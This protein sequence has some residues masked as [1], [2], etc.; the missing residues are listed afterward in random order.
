MTP[1]AS[2]AMLEKLALLK[3]AL[4]RAPALSSASSAFWRTELS[5]PAEMPVRVFVPPFSP[6]MALPPVTCT[7]RIPPIARTTSRLRREQLFNGALELIWRVRLG[8]EVRAFNKQSFHLVG[9]G[10]ACRVEHTQ[11]WRRLDGL[12]CKLT[13]AEDRCFEMDIGKECV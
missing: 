10:I 7:C 12:V 6:V 4:C 9:N 2:V 5:A 11:F 13:P 3:I 1:L 8:K